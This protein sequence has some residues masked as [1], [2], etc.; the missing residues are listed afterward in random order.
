MLDCVFVA[1][2]FSPKQHRN[3]HPQGI[4]MNSWHL[5]FY[6]HALYWRL[7]LSSCS[8]I[9][10]TSIDCQ[11]LPTNVRCQ[12][13]T[14]HG[15]GLDELDAASIVAFGWEWFVGSNILRLCQSDAAQIR[16]FETVLGD[17]TELTGLYVNNNSPSGEISAGL[18]NLTNL[19]VLS[20]ASNQLN[21]TIP[22]FLGS[23]VQ[24]TA[25]FLSDNVVT[26][27]I[28]STLGNLS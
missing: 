16:V 24:L 26:G 5:R 6:K 10:T 8:K 21:G 19:I 25:L 22:T 4:P 2:I 14:G 9:V 18:G 11:W 28:P 7:T 23:L 13:E 20:L 27:I 1:D 3:L 12:R 15:Q 17:W